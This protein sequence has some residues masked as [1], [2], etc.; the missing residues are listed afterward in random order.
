[1][2]HA[3]WKSLMGRKLR[4]L[5]SALSIVLGIA[6]V[7]GSLIFTNLLQSS[8]TQIVEGTLADINVAPEGNSGPFSIPDRT[9][10]LSDGDIAEIAAIDGVERVE[11]GISNASMYP[12]DKDGNLLALG[13][14]PGMATTFSDAPAAGGK[15]G[16]HIIEGRAPQANNEVAID[17]S[18]L[19]RSGLAVGDT[20]QVSTPFRGIED[21]LIVGVATWGDGGTLGASYLFFTAE[22]MQTQVLDGADG[23]T[24]AWV[25][26]D[27]QAD[28]ESVNEAVN[29]VLPEAFVAQTGDKLAEQV[30]ENLG[31]GL[32]FATTFL[33]IFAAIALLVA[34]LLIMNTFSILVKQRSREL[35][36]LR[37]LGAQRSQIR[38]SVLTEAFIVGLVGATVGIAA[39]YGLV[40]LILVGMRAAGVELGS[41]TPSLT[42][43]AVLASYLVALVI[44]M[45]AAWIPARRASITR[46][47]EAMSRAAGAGPHNL[48]WIPYIGLSLMPVGIAAVI[49][50]LAFK[51]PEPSWWVGLGLAA[52]LVGGVLGT[53][54]LGSPLVW[55]FTK[56][57]QVLFGEVGKMAGRNASRQPQRTAAT[58]ATL[59]IGLAL[60]T[61]V[62]ILAATTSTSLRQAM[63]EDQRGD[64]VVRSVNFRPFAAT[65]VEQM[66]KVQGV[67]S[68]WSWQL[69]RAMIED[70]TDVSVT[71]ITPES[72]ANAIPTEVQGDGLS[73]QGNTAVVDV[74]F[75]Q[76]HDLTLGD[77]IA[78]I[79]IDQ[80]PHELLIS[81]VYDQSTTGL[82]LGDFLVNPSQFG[83][84]GDPKLV[85]QAVVAIEDGANDDALQQALR[86]TVSE[87]PTVSVSSNKEYIDQMVG[88]FDQ[89]IAIIYALLALA[90]IISV[91]GIINTL[92]LSVLERTREIGL[93]RAV[94][95]SRSQLRR[96][97]GLESVIVAVL[98]SVLGVILGVAFGVVLVELLRDQGLTHRRIPWLQLG[99]FVALSALFGVLAALGPARRASRMRVLDAISDQ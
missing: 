67:E 27:P 17:P 40:W 88:Q 34:S 56:L 81:G 43:Q 75:A 23:Y 92:G 60:V 45:L 9:K 62:A 22:Q 78:L 59:M 3:T 30:E 10:V 15:Q 70:S 41:L 58:A 38:H 31:V 73:R 98:G 66:A 48:G 32:G 36:L 65:A 7:S 57:Y 93:L 1:M 82:P 74:N 86:E 2:L 33:L 12:L 94:G 26:V 6:F 63:Q 16:A 90:I 52:I 19:E 71:G 21:F 42:W 51:V 95:L 83:Y 39:G 77:S 53:A 13:G 79:G 44:T 5:M 61:T 8:F 99:I 49:C 29:E 14:A 69:G 96:M 11:G 54:V 97:V 25:V 50:G 91:L 87:M 68:V 64:F 4:L 46:P 18:T 24:D 20:L 89:F 28:V 85:D 55:L 84:F 47:V 35:A 72:L 80:Q 76:D 37:A